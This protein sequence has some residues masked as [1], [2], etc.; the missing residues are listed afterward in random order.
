MNIGIFGATGLVGKE[1]IKLLENNHLNIKFNN[2]RVFASESSI[3]KNISFRGLNLI[4]ETYS[5]KIYSELDV[6]ILCTSANISKDIVK[7]AKLYN[8]LII[9]NSSAFR[10]DKHVPLVVPEINGH[11]IK[12]NNIIANPNCC[13]ALLTMVLYPLHLRFNIKKVIVSTYQSASG[14]G[15]KGLD[16]LILNP[17]E[18]YPV[19]GRQYL[20]NVFSHNSEIDLESLYNDEE[21]KIML[22]TKKILNT[23]IKISATCVRVPTI[24]A[25]AESVSIEFSNKVELNEIRSILDNQVGVIVEDNIKSGEFPEPIKAENKFDV[26]VGRIRYDLSDESKKSINLFLCGDQLL[27]GAALNAYQILAHSNQSD[28]FINKYL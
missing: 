19:F 11:L 12:G 4:V 14:A 16:E 24:R 2:L 18:S 26:M 22:E 23:N 21:V 1:F 3:G 25:H 28:Q 8:C 20:Y 17:I 6:L 5:N 13:T 27:K 10:Y 7:Q 9:D 15:Q